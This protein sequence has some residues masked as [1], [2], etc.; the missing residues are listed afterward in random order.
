MQ[1]DTDDVEDTVIRPRSRPVASERAEVALDD[2]VVR[3]PN[4]GGAAMPGVAG[5]SARSAPDDDTI[6]RELR[7]ERHGGGTAGA[8]PRRSDL[9]DDTVLR[10]SDALPPVVGGV[11]PAAPPSLPPVPETP[12]TRVPAI[13]VGS[14]VIRLDRPVVI[15][16]RPALP[17]VVRG[18]VPELV[19]VASPR[20]Q[21][22]STHVLVHA[23]G[24]AAVVE[25]LRSTNGTVVRP[26]GSAPYRMSSG[27]SI[28]ALTGTVVEI[29]DGVTVE[30]LSPHLRLVPTVDGDPPSPDDLPIRTTT[31]TPR[32]PRERS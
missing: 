19:T 4:H 17:R 12:R 1:D 27:G 15:G 5:A 8:S 23:E 26:A 14:R 24:E 32:T 21:V 16:R 25:D 7:P 20:G 9:D 13:R 6:V 31:G 28:V 2:T 29:G 3:V 11:L 18:E 30:V 10:A 22:S